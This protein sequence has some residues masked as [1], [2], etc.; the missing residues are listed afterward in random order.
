MRVGLVWLLAFHGLVGAVQA[1]TDESAPTEATSE[2]DDR[3]ARIHFESGRQYFDEGE[4]ERAVEEFTR[5]YELS[6]RPPLL[7]NIASGLERL[8]RYGE[9]ADRMQA[10]HDQAEDTVPTR[11]VLLRRIANLRERAARAEAEA[12]PDVRNPVNPADPEP[13]EL[14]PPAPPSSSNGRILG[15]AISF[16]VAGAGLV[17]FGVLGGMALGERSSVEDGCGA[18]RSCSSSDVSKMDGLAL[19]ADLGLAIAAAGAV[20]GVLVLVL[21]DSNDDEGATAAVVPFVGREAGG[22]VVRGTF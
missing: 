8:G 20:A 9:A 18:T 16:G 21:M 12:E 1:Q 22:A 4:Y 7:M 10:Y 17:T 6:H 5:A 3:R 13:G 11:D 15:A 19:G 2:A 14:P